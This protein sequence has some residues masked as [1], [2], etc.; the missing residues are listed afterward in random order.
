MTPNNVSLEQLDKNLKMHSIQN[1]NSSFSDSSSLKPEE[2]SKSPLIG[3]NSLDSEEME[4]NS[5]LS[6]K[7]I[8]KR[9]HKKKNLKRSHSE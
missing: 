3:I 4:D 6:P 2:E 7:N 5:L 8:S 1:L 9:H